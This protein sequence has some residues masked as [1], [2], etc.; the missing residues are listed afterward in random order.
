MFH[1][2]VCRHVNTA[3]VRNRDEERA[4]ID[5]SAARV[6]SQTA[7]QL[8]ATS[9]DSELIRSRIYSERCRLNRWRLAELERLGIE[10]VE[11][12]YL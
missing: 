5:L 8:A 4:E 10:P 9:I 2:V 3:A 12:V 11:S 6:I 1:F 7:E